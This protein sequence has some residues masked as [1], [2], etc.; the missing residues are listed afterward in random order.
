[1]LETGGSGENTTANVAVVGNAPSRQLTLFDGISTIVSLMVGSGIF[2]TAGEVQSEVGSPGL[3]LVLWLVTGLLALTGA[4]CYAELG[5]M[6]PGSGGEAQYLQR[7]IGRLAVYLF[8]WTSIMLL[9]PGTV[10]LLAVATSRYILMMIALLLGEWAISEQ[11]ELFGLGSSSSE[12]VVC[13]VAVGFVLLVTLLSAAS[14]KWSNRIQGV[15]TFGKIGALGLVILSGFY[16]M[17]FRDSS[18]V[19]ANLGRPFDGTKVEFKTLAGALNGGLW[20]FEG[21]NNLNIVAGDL[22]K[23]AVNL[24]LAIWSSMALVLSLYLLTLLGYYAVIP[25]A[26]V[27]ISTTIGIDFGREVFGQFGAVLMPLLIAASTFG[28]AL[29]SMVTSSEIIVLAAGEKQ[30]PAVFG[31][32]SRH[33]GTAANAY[34][35]QGV[36]A[37]VLVMFSGNKA[38][39]AMYTVPSWIFYGLCVFV[40][41]KLRWTEPKAARP[42]R[43]FLSTPVLFLA[44]CCWLLVT[45]FIA[46]MLHVGLSFGVVLL[47]VPLYYLSE[48]FISKSAVKKELAMKEST[49]A[50]SPLMQDKP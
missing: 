43:V 40:L 5:T 9:K 49:E 28:S 16:Y 8:N 13:G 39:L 33:S 47:G 26:Q 36:L 50:K 10:A 18:I 42:Y 38:L 7:G 45:G 14:T 19:R 48:H 20:A 3:A 23:P 25:A 35:M 11:K 29:S 32:V 30:I 2:T 21:W 44:A 1:M 22:V 24:P 34:I 27:A 17:I 41:L 31:R 37:A 12:W 15:L 46:S 6:I 4:L